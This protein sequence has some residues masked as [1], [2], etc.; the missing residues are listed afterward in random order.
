M[1][2]FYNILKSKAIRSIKKQMW[3]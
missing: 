2:R 1:Y 3:K